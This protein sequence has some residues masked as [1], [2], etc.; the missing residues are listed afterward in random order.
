MT[1][2]RKYAKATAYEN[3]PDQVKNREARNRARAETEKKIGHKLPHDMEVDHKNPLGAGGS[4]AITNTRV[5]PESRNR[6]W[7][8]G[9]KGYKV[10]SV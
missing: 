9:S 6:A 4:A 1:A 10:K 7:R 8:A 2:P 3:Q 5:I